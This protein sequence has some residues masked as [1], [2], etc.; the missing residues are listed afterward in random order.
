[1]S[2]F[3]KATAL[4]AVLSL[5]NNVLAS[6]SPVEARDAL[7]TVDLGYSL[8]RATVF[9]ESGQYYNFSNIRYAQPPTGDLRFRAP[10]LPVKDRSQVFTG[11]KN[12]ICPQA[13]PAWLATA[14]LFL[15]QYFAGK[16]NF[17]PADFNTSSST[18]ALPAQDPA[19][20]EDCLFLDVHVPKKIFD[21]RGKK[22]KGAPVLVQIYGGGYTSGDKRSV[23]NPAGLLQRAQNND[24]AGLIYVSL[25]YRLG[26]FGWLS[27][28]TFQEDGTANA[29][30]YDQRMALFWV[31]EHIAKFGGDPERVTVFGES[32]GGG[33]ILHQ[34]T[35]FG[36]APAPFQQAVPQ[37][38]GFSPIVS[39]VQQESTFNA[40][41]SLL[42]VTSIAQARSLPYQALQTANIIQI[43]LQSAYGTFTYG[44]VVDGVFAP[45]LPGQLLARGQHAK[46]VKVMVGHNANEVCCLKSLLLVETD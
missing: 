6:A 43:G 8:Q 7:P 46:N 10:K 20:T 23:G 24:N 45:Q 30:L 12:R 37:S 44:P 16:T 11:E 27:G 19:T 15:P 39:T 36:G 41:L 35:A 4:V 29:A 42:N 5:T 2:S 22:G 34:I 33:S 3:A 1:M 21:K 14:E 31:R 26:A 40:Y 17:S 32:A 18:N 9:N 25:N 38:P 13:N 28:P